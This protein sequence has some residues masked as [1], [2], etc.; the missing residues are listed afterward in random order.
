MTCKRIG[1][2]VVTAAIGGWAGVLGAKP[3]DTP[4]TVLVSAAD[5]NGAPVT[6]LTAADLVVKEGGKDQV[7]ASL[8]PATD[9]MDVAILVD[10]EGSGSF[11][12]GV[13]TF[14]QAVGEHA[15]FSIRVLNPQA[16]KV[17]DYGDA[18][19]SVIQGALDKLGRRGKIQGHGEQL[20]ELVE[21]RGESWAYREA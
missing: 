14:L 1:L 2:F 13:L 8:Q 11:Q 19:V 3:A 6:D 21:M 20:L 12:E 4:R 17:L 16:D 9:P 18:D 5:A 7:I 10:D 15:K